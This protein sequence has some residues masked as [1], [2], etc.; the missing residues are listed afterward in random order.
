MKQKGEILV[1]ALI[2]A[3][4]SGVFA[5]LIIPSATYDAKKADDCPEYREDTNKDQREYC[6]LKKDADEA[7]YKIKKK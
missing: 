3:F 6:Y 7:G 5:T 4:I 2:V 1:A